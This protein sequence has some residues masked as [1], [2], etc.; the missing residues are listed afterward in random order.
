MM[1]RKNSVRLTNNNGKKQFCD[2]GLIFVLFCFTTSLMGNSYLLNFDIIV[3][4]Y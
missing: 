2:S 1:A 4:C 3:K